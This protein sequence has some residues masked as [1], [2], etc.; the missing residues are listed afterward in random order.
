M[1]NKN[2]VLSFLLVFSFLFAIGQSE[3][4]SDLEGTALRTW[5][6]DNWY[7][8]KFQ[9]QG[10]NNARTAMYSTIDVRADGR[11]YGVYSGFSQQA[12]STTYLNPINA[13]HTIP[14]SKF[15][16]A[17]PMK[18]DIMHLFPT[19]G[20]VNG[21]RGSNPF[22]DITD[23]QTDK[24]Y[25]GDQ[26]GLNDIS[27]IPQ[28]NIDDYSEKTSSAFEPR[29]DHKGDV[30]RAVFYFF[31]VYDISIDIDGLALG[32]DVDMLYQWHQQDPVDDWERTRNERIEDTQGNRNPYVDY[33]DLVCSAWGFE[34]VTGGTGGGNNGSSNTDASLVMTGVFDATLT[35]GSPKGV[36][37]YVIKDIADLSL[38][39]IGSANN[40]GGTDG[41]EV[42]LTGSASSGDFIYVAYEASTGDFNS[43]F[44]FD[45]NTTDPSA[46]NINGDDAIELF[47]DATGAFSGGETV[48]DVFGDINTDGSGEAWEYLDGWAY[49]V[50]DSGP[51]GTTFQL[52]E[53]SFSGIDALDGVTT[54][55][56]A[57]KPF[58]IGSF[59]FAAACDAPT[60]QVS[61]LTAVS[62]NDNNIE[63]SWTRGDADGVIV[64][65]S[66]AADDSAAPTSGTSYQANATFGSGEEVEEGNYVVYVGSGTTVTILDLNAATDYNFQA[67]EYKGTTPCFLI[68][69]PALLSA[70]TTTANDQ[71]TTIT[72]S[73]APLSS[74]AISSL[75][76]AKEDAID[77]LKFVITDIGNGDGLPTNM[78][79]AVFSPGASNNANWSEI[80][81]GAILSNGTITS[82]ATSIS[83]E[84]IV[85]QLTPIMSFTDGSSTALTLSVY[86][87]KTQI[88]Q[89]T[90]QFEVPVAQAF[91]A[92]GTGSLFLSSLSESVTSA[93]HSVEVLAT[94]FLIDA[95]LSAKVASDFKITVSATDINNNVDH[96]ARTL[97]LSMTENNGRL[98]S[99]TGL[100][101][102]IMD[103]GIYTW[104]DLKISQPGTYQFSATDNAITTVS[105]S[106]AITETIVGLFFSEYIEG[107]SSNKAIELF[108]AS[109]EEISLSTFTIERFNNGVT[110]PSFVLNLSDVKASIGPG[111]VLVIANPSANEA[112]LSEADATGEITYY[113]GDDALALVESGEIVDMFGKI[114]E[115]PGSNW[116][117]GAT[118]AT[119]EYTLIR[120]SNV[121]GGNPDPLGSFGT[122]DENSEWIVMPQDSFADIGLHTID[123]NSCT[124]PQV[125]ATSLSVSGITESELKLSWTRGDG[126]QIMVI[127]KALN[128]VDVSLTE[129]D[130]FS[131]NLS[132]GT[133]DEIGDGNFVLYIGDGTEATITNLVSGTTY[134]FSAIEFNLD[135]TCYATS[136]A[137]VN[138]TTLTPNDQDSD[139]LAP[140]AQIAA[141]ILTSEAVTLDDA[142]TVFK[143]SITDKG[144]ADA[145]S[146]LITKLNIEPAENNTANWSEVLAGAQ[147]TTANRTI[148]STSISNESIAFDLTDAFEITSGSTVEFE[149]SI[150]M[151]STVT[152]GEDIAFTIP[153]NHGFIS[154]GD[155]SLLKTTLTE[156]ITSAV[157]EIVVTATTL[158]LEYETSINGENLFSLKVTATDLLS[159]VDK[160]PRTVSISLANGNGQFGSATGLVDQNMIDGVYEWTDLEYDDTG[161]IMLSI[162]ASNLSGSAT[163]EVFRITSSLIFSE[164]IEGGGFNKAVEIYNTSQSSISLRNYSLAIYGNGSL[165][166]SYTY[167][168]SDAQESID[169]GELIV[170]SHE[171]ADPAI[172]ALATATNSSVCNFNGN[173]AIA[174]LGDGKV[175]DVIGQIGDNPST[176]WSV[177]TDGATSEHTLVR[178]FE[179][180]EGNPIGLGSF[181]SDDQ[182]SEWIT[183]EK[184]DFSNLG[185]HEAPASVFTVSSANFDTNFGSIE[186]G[187]ESAVRSY[188]VSGE[189][190]T[191][192]VSIT[193]PNGFVIAKSND[194]FGTVIELEPQS[195][196]LN[197][198]I[199]V[200]F[201]PGEALAYSGNI[202]HSSEDFETSSVMVSGTGLLPSPVMS[203]DQASLSG[204]FGEVAT[205]AFSDPQQF[206]ISAQHLIADV[207]V[208]IPTNF[209]LSETETFDIINNGGTS[210]LLIP[211]EGEI[212]AK[213]LFVRFAPTVDGTFDET[214]KVTTSGADDIDITLSGNAE[215]ALASS[216]ATLDQ[217]GFYPN[218]AADFIWIAGND[219]EEKGVTIMSLDG[220]LIL[221]E[222]VI[223][224]RSIDVSRLERGIYLLRINADGNSKTSKLIKE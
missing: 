177:G 140:T 168:L 81:D 205:G 128:N 195:G 87:N 15:G 109:K 110:V 107:N 125:A 165:T 197:E 139:I 36:E 93:S 23:S 105:S 119:S 82:E 62:V 189:N 224:K 137:S 69:S 166:S 216:S 68:G 51:N 163:F 108:N 40:G 50:A 200:K 67:Y 17:S 78:S 213:T 176:N 169:A 126:G 192:N 202:T 206:V 91:D 221:S 3:P 116:P 136:D 8:G 208:N 143:F 124:P 132:F 183:L 5:L 154:S 161:E 181:G 96:A 70:T 171:D 112:I 210:F 76:N 118:G 185:K 65:A 148:Q 4:P 80:I 218:P 104:Q 29:E 217:W 13:E 41:R 144:T 27:S 83:N 20:E 145:L 115:D 18:S 106:I 25:I 44:G 61:N 142:I 85:F 37:L 159:N 52:S 64:I 79:R 147:L 56:T 94:Q 114:G 53:W 34:C 149:L 129:G 100:S 186:I 11:V 16:S 43:Y 207:M 55:S 123:D 164:Y 113:N 194:N 211:L 151:D 39:G 172:L 111:E 84:S 32:G 214:M 182:S 191:L 212:I 72:K 155:G 167:A 47:Y 220:K 184:D 24:W 122:T 9:D 2:T 86:L 12:K 156:S 31:T 117:V 120:K 121:F 209:E 71:N 22:D 49:R 33:P 141:S 57:D 63:L 92:E 199:S 21:A 188:Q 152:D 42:G 102:K 150:W 77:V 73:D 219:R 173:D 203:I 162:V 196:I 19:H 190:L 193:A 138:A 46:T 178:K 6:K 95:P 99:T 131:G 7:T 160:A 97:S 38:Y 35:G 103:T 58:P 14:Q 10:Y 134:S 60:S 158:S 135:P 201:M 179:V 133:G 89:A 98:S 74:I 45:P 59:T 54:N 26:S 170:I 204:A 88:D 48:I 101:E 187:A 90:L 30:A 153:V 174:I 146:T 222:I 223:G 198:T 157:H 175:I 130:T 180:T 28:S 127:G 1:L 75:A 66:L 215:T